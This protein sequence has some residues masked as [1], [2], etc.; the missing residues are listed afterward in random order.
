MVDTTARMLAPLIVAAVEVPRSLPRRGLT[1]SPREGRLSKPKFCGLPAEFSAR[2]PLHYVARSV[3]GSATRR[4]ERSA[5]AK[6]WPR[7]RAKNPRGGVRA[8]HEAVRKVLGSSRTLCVRRGGCRCALIIIAVLGAI[9]AG[10]LAAAKIQPV[11]PAS[12]TSA[13]QLKRTGGAP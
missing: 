6:R 10:V 2:Q 7:R 12:A 8:A 9:A 4:V 5:I 1:P 3:G 11:L 13:L